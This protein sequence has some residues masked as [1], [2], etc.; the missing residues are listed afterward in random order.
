MRVPV[1]LDI[2]FT[3]RESWMQALGIARDISLGGMFIETASPASYGVGVLVALRRPDAQSAVLL[4]GTVRWTH[5][6]GMG[7]QFGLLGA[8]ETY[9]I[10]S[11]QHGA[12]RS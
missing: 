1:D 12:R 11:L 8:R 6:D 9:A 10:V 2:E 4:Q 3:S 5:P 7:V